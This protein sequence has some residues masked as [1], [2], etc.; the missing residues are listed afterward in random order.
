M[1]SLQASY[2]G[3]KTDLICNAKPHVALKVS[4]QESSLPVGARIDKLKLKNAKRFETVNKNLEDMAERQKR[5]LLDKMKKRKIELKKAMELAAQKK[6]DED[7]SNEKKLKKF[8]T[9]RESK[10]AMDK[11]AE[12]RAYRDY[13]MHLKDVKSRQLS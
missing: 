3:L 9:I 2:D 6:A 8:Q 5:E 4:L 10:A 1:A 12:Q 11:E 13:R 7:Y